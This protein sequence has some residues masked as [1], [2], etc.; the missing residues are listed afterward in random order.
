MS[1]KKLYTTNR[2]SRSVIR[3]LKNVS[4]I[5]T[6]KRTRDFNGN[7]KDRP[8]FNIL[9]RNPADQ[10]QQEPGLVR[11]TPQ[12]ADAFVRFSTNIISMRYL[13]GFYS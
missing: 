4:F 12:E 9:L 2:T 11:L 1:N 3:H 13:N 7:I 10:S 6:N 8:H 5:F